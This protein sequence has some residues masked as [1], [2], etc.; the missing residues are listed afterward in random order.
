MFMVDAPSPL[1]LLVRK[2]SHHVALSPDDCAALSNLP[3]KLRLFDH[4]TYLL[5]EGDAPQYCSVLVSGFAY[6]Q[7]L[8]GE[9]AR[10]I[11][12]L[13]IPGEAI[14]L[15]SLYLDVADHNIQTLTRAEVA[16]V[17]RAAMREL[18]QARPAIAHAVVVENLVEAS[19]L[20]EW[21]LSIGRRDAQTRLAHLLCEVALRLE[22]QGLPGGDGYELPM[23]QEQLG[24]ALGLTAVHV[25]R[26][27]KA[28]EAQGLIVRNRRHVG[29]PQWQA[30]RDVG[31]FNAR[32]LHLE[33]QTS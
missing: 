4:S 7:K 15:Q 17:P 11:V 30:L 25:N 20:R 6:R 3:H 5:R 23:T 14:D 12:S 9:G 18:I 33:R 13:H 29:I 24:D 1:A 19:I 2:F 22:A 32:Y 31:D 28:L 16:L 10:Q 27:L 8:T 26:T 21:T